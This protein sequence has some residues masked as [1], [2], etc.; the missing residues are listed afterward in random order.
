[1]TVAG[2]TST[3]RVTGTPSGYPA[4][5]ESNVKI[6][7]IDNTLEVMTDYAIPLLKRLGG[8]NAFTTNNTKIEWILFDTWSDRFDL[9]ATLA[10]AGVTLTMDGSKAHRV[11]RGTV[12]KIGDELLWVSAMASAT[13]LTVARGYAGTSDVE[14]L[15]GVQARIVG[16]TEVEGTDIVLRGSALRTVPFNYHSIYK[17]GS[18]ESFAQS[19]A[20]VYTRRG[21][22]LPEMMADSVSQYWVQL[23]AAVIEGERYEGSA[24][25]DP[26]MMGGL[27]FF[28]T[29]ANGATVIDAGGAKLSRALLNQAFDGTYDAVGVDK[30]ARTVLTGKGAKRVLYEE[31]GQPIVRAQ[32]GTT[33][34]HEDLTRLENEYGAFDIIGPFKRIP[35]DELWMVN[36]ALIQVGHYGRLGRLHEIIIPTAGDYTSRGLYAMNTTKFKGIAGIVRLHNFVTS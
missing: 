16:F 14:H 15:S 33:V 23:E 9:D 35:E 21:A 6:R 20:G 18:S 8:A 17:T 10:A 4:E 32:E 12:L 11:P 25:T 29:S 22:T 5:Q 28:G 26:P 13:T 36:I 3:L 1:M 2:T 30:M 34:F 24:A 31:Y 7:F 19:E 27:R